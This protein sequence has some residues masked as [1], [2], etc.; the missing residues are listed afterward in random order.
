MGRLAELGILG[1]WILG[2]DNR[3]ASQAEAW[4]HRLFGLM[5]RDVTA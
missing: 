4:E 1:L 5:A 3:N 2:L